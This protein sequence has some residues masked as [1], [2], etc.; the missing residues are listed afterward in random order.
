M[1]W[2]AILTTWKKIY[3]EQNH[4]MGGEVVTEFKRQKRR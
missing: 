1:E 2:E 3:S 4:F